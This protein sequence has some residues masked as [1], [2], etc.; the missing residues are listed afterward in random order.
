MA[1]SGDLLSTSIKLRRGL[2]SIEQ[3]LG[4]DQLPEVFFPLLFSFF[5]GVI[6]FFLALLGALIFFLF[7][8]WV[9]PLLFRLG[10]RARPY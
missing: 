8:V 9:S 4:L 6:S 7:T 2:A 1:M 3:A 5:V 10:I